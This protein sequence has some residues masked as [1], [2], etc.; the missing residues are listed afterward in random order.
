[1]PGSRHRSTRL[2]EAAALC[3]AAV[4]TERAFLGRIGLELR[5]DFVRILTLD[6]VTGAADLPQSG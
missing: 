1:L 6:L 5:V 3:A 2:R 4:A